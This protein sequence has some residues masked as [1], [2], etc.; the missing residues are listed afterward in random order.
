MFRRRRFFYRSDGYR[1]KYV[2]ASIFLIAIVLLTAFM[3]QRFLVISEVSAISDD[4]TCISGDSIKKEAVDFRKTYFDT[5]EDLIA[6]R[7]KKKYQCVFEVFFVKRFPDKL[8]IKIEARKPVLVV[9]PIFEKEVGM[10][11]ES[12]AT[13]SSQSAKVDFSINRA[14]GSADFLVDKT[15]LAYAFLK[16]GVDLPAVGYEKNEIKIGDNLPG[17]IINQVMSLLDF[18]NRLS[19]PRGGLKVVRER[20][21]MIDGKPKIIFDLDKNRHDESFIKRQTASLQLILQKATIDS[22]GLE[23]VDLRF[24]KPVVVYS[25]K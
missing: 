1:K 20:N 5:R 12:E 21:L 6:Q 15:G 10:L 8:E 23:S 18:V 19:L 24:D 25:S 22:K 7:I 4:E 3:G 16:E 11:I 2:F 14:T 13:P 17:S 9:F